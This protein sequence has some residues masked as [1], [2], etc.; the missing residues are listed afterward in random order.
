MNQPYLHPVTINFSTLKGYQIHSL[1]EVA[2]NPKLTLFN[3]NLEKDFFKKIA[4]DVY[5]PLLNILEATDTKASVIITGHFLM[6]AKET[7]PKLVSNLKKLIRNKKIHI[8][9]NAFHGNSL[10]S[11][12]HSDWWAQSIQFTVEQIEEVLDTSM[13]GIYIDQLFRGLELER[14]THHTTNFVSRHKLPKY[15]YHTLKLSELRKFNG[16]TVSWIH[17][18]NDCQ[19]TIFYAPNSLFFNVNDIYFTPNRKEAIKAL[20]LKAGSASSRLSIRRTTPWKPLPI[21]PAPRI[22]EKYSTS[23]YSPLERAVIRLWEYGAYKIAALYN[24]QPDRFTSVLFRDFSRLQ[25]AEFLRFL[26]KITY[27]NPELVLFS[28]PFEAFVHMQTSI[29]QLEYQ[30]DIGYNIDKK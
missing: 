23:L 19:C 18:D 11:L 14:V 24:N 13:Q 25:D 2:K 7:S 5:I 16:N 21:S 27:K 28:S 8:I 6:L 15:G 4:T 3:R 9:A 12:Y 30:I 17:E 10:T 22:S 29:K 26:K 1:V 20:A